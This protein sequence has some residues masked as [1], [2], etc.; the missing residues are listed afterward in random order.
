MKK[1][2]LIATIIFGII[3]ISCSNAEPKKGK[4]TEQKSDSTLVY[5]CPM[6]PKVTGKKGDMCNE[7]GMYLEPVK[8]KSKK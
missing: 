4:K 5:A 7:C 8:K 6:H 2:F 3:L 1:L